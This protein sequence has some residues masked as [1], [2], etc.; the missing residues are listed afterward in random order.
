MATEA[1]NAAGVSDG[2]RVW[3]RL[4]S[5]IAPG[6]SALAVIEIGASRAVN[7]DGLLERWCGTLGPEVG[8]LA[9]R[10]LGDADRGVIARVED[11]LALAFP[12][13][14]AAVVQAV[15]T[16]LDRAG[17]A[18]DPGRGRDARHGASFGELLD[19][20]LAGC[21]SE[22]G[23]D[24][25][26]DQRRAWR[27]ADGFDPS[28]VRART[29]AAALLPLLVPPI[30][31]AVGPANVGKSTLTNAL[32]SRRVA[33]VD[34]APGTTRDHV[35][36]TLSLAGL[37][38]RWLDT[39]GV[40][41]RSSGEGDAGEIERIATE[42]LRPVLA[43]APVI[44]SCGDAASG[45]LTEDQL[46]EMGVQADATIVRCLTRADLGGAAPAGGAACSAKTGD[47]LDRLAA[48]VRGAAVPCWAI[49]LNEPWV[50]DERLVQPGC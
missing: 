36:V 9:L 27:E 46:A 24:L 21:E 6:G 50:F 13:G 11:G 7:L 4:V 41:D 26:L 38:V 33:A 45:W 2:G 39:P 20:T 31:A 18:Q 35:G 1:R 19:E 49:V 40:R 37:T 43:G 23:V 32:A 34:D 44:V 14:G 10:R 17:S 15:M 25:L 3:H 29:R 30:V 22:L 28:S 42:L 12:H 16:S 5:S 47:G 8:Q 48:K